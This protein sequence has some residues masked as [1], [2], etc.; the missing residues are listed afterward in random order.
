MPWS[1]VLI[2]FPSNIPKFEGKASEDPGAHI[3]T[4]HLWFSLNSLNDDSIWLRIFQRMLTHVVAKWHIELPS[5][6]YDSFLYLETVFL[7]HF[8]LFV[9]YDAGTDLLLTF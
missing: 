3:T 8:Q 4:F 6:S 2:K 5:S 1:P 7:N 9:W